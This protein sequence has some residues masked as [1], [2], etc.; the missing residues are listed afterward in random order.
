MVGTTRPAEAHARGVRLGF[1]MGFHDATCAAPR[2]EVLRPTR[3]LV[4]CDCD[5]VVRGSATGTVTENSACNRLISASSLRFTL[6]FRSRLSLT[7]RMRVACA[8]RMSLP[9]HVRDPFWAATCS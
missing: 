2:P 3:K 5:A 1:G 7:I 6:R 8:P 4:Q 9:A